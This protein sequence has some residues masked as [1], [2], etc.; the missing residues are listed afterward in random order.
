MSSFPPSLFT[1]TSCTRRGVS[2]SAGSACWENDSL[3][4]MY[5]VSFVSRCDHLTGPGYKRGALCTVPVSMP[6]LKQTHLDGDE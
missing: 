1:V 5:I 2:A 4:S 3:H 6:S